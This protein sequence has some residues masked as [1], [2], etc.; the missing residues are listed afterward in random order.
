M[1]KNKVVTG[2]PDDNTPF[3]IRGNTK[4]IT[5]TLE[6][7]DKSLINCFSD[8]QIKVNTDKCHLFLNSR[9][10]NTMKIGKLCVKNPLCENL[11]RV[12]FDY[13][14]ILKKYIADICQKASRKIYTLLNLVPY[15]RVSKR[16]A[17]MNACFKSQ[18][19]HCPL[20]WM[21]CIQIFKK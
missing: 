21:W 14:L 18:F 17:L 16:R 13:R 8:K 2:C 3:V 5:K 10:P 7:I 1:M 15:M 11:L 4:G 6:E 19:N 9:I 20:I 12:N